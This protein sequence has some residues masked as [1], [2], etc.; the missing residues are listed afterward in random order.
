MLQAEYILDLQKQLSLM[1]GEAR[2]DSNGSLSPEDSTIPSMTPADKVCPNL[3]VMHE[4]TGI[5]SR[6]WGIS[7]AAR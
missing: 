4:V 7:C 3:S 5:I 6:E 2:R 1:G